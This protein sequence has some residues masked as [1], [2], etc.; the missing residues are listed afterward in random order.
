[1]LCPLHAYAPYTRLRAHLQSMQSTNAIH[2]SGPVVYF[3]AV[4]VLKRTQSLFIPSQFYLELAS[5]Q[6]PLCEIQSSII[7]CKLQTSLCVCSTFPHFYKSPYVLFS[8]FGG[9]SRPLHYHFMQYD[10]FVIIIIL[11]YH[12]HCRYHYA[13]YHRCQGAAIDVRLPLIWYA[14]Q[15]SAIHFCIFSTQKCVNPLHRFC[16][17]IYNSPF[18]V[19]WFILLSCLHRSALKA[20]LYIYFIWQTSCFTITF[21]CNSSH[22]F[23]PSVVSLVVY[24]H[25][26]SCASCKL[27]CVFVRHFVPINPIIYFSLFSVTTSVRFHIVARWQCLYRFMQDDSFERSLFTWAFWASRTQLCFIAIY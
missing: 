23:H 3:D 15:W 8:V 2:R 25:P 26:S 20:F 9:S 6:L 17:S 7:L 27:H 24:L 12:Y 5:L 18:L 4:S 16:N 19:L 22:L 1:M 14:I 21:M 13:N 10:S 11:C